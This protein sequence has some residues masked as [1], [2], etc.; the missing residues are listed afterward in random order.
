MAG[1]PRWRKPRT[2]SAPHSSASE[3]TKSKAR[4]CVPSSAASLAQQ[5]FENL[6]DRFADWPVGS[7][8]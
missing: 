5:H 8:I 2:I 4:F 6:K 1:R 3:R 7:S